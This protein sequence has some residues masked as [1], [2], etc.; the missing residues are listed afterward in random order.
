[1]PTEDRRHLDR[2]DEDSREQLR[3]YRESGDRRDR[4]AVVE[5]HRGLAAAIARTYDHTGEPFEDR[6]Q[7]ALLGVVKA[8]ERFD[9][10]Q[11]ATFA[12]FAAVTARGELRRHFRDHGWGVHVPR[13]VQDLRYQVRAATDILLARNRTMPTAADVAKLLGVDVDQVIEALCADESYRPRSIDSGAARPLSATLAVATGDDHERVDA[14]DAFDNLVAHCPPRLR[15]VLE[16]RYAEG[17][18]Q[19]E[20]ATLLGISQVHVSR[21]LRQ[22]HELVREAAAH[23][24]SAAC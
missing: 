20:I 11:G 17:L 1:L 19:H 3:R 24:V 16:L 18:K 2:L 15:R 5:A 12:A 21:L 8:A 23:D 13:T 22:G 7:V 10:D 9:P 14:A 6:L 4:N